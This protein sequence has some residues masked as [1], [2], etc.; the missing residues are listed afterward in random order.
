M[1]MWGSQVTRQ[2]LQQAISRLHTLNMIPEPA[3]VNSTAS[4]SHS[5]QHRLS[6]IREIEIASNLAFLSAISD[7]NQRV[8]AVCVEES[9]CGDEITIRLAS[10]TGDLRAVTSEFKKLVGILEQASRRGW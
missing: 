1:A 6:S 4:V 5:A 9:N 8:M 10:N 7:D 3:K 2:Q